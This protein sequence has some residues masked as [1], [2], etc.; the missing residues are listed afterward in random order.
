MKYKK[1]IKKNTNNKKSDSKILYS[2]D[3]PYLLVT[4]VG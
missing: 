2:R 1:I 3:G 4:A